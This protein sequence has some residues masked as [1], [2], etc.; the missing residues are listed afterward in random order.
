MH[1]LR[2]RLLQLGVFFLLS[3][4][5][6]ARDRTPVQA[7]D[8]PTAEQIIQTIKGT[9]Y[10]DTRARQ[11]AALRWMNWEVNELHM[12]GLYAGDK[13]DFLQ[14]YGA[15][16]DRLLAEMKDSPMGP[17]GRGD[18]T[19]E[20][21]WR[22]LTFAYQNDGVLHQSVLALAGP[23]L[24]HQMNEKS[25]FNA[26]R[27]V[28]YQADSKR[29][30]EVRLKEL[31]LER[32]AMS[33]TTATVMVALPI[34]YGLVYWIWRRLRRHGP[35]DSMGKPSWRHAA[36][37]VSIPVLFYFISGAWAYIAYAGLNRMAAV[38]IL[39]NLTIMVMTARTAI[40]AV[41]VQLKTAN[42]A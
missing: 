12:L 22:D 42:A 5:L 38:A 32:E 8:V 31:K 29:R 23:S 19:A 21:T 13:G 24:L 33:R 16:M 15:A 3:A 37:R 4:P 40:L 34:L 39:V 14:R 7:K 30:T 18:A 6:Y 2:T 41:R 28:E 10:R 1:T 27:A 11:F 26:Q 20:Q 35:S 36:A 9:D 25:S 17:L